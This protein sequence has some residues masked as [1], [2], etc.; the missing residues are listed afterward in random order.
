MKGFRPRGPAVRRRRPAERRRRGENPRPD[1][2]AE[3]RVDEFEDPRDR[4]EVRRERRRPP[5]GVAVAGGDVRFE[6]CPAEPVDRLVTV[7]DEEEAARPGGFC[8]LLAV[9]TPAAPV[10]HGSPAADAPVAGTAPAGTDGA[11]TDARPAGTCRIPGPVGASATPCPRTV[12]EGR[13]RRAPPKASSSAISSWS[14]SVSWNSSI[15][16]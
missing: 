1:D 14:G 7:T 15:S 3:A 12:N 13:S 9:A 6:V 4:P 2:R 10:L 11:G 5:A 16:R 8:A